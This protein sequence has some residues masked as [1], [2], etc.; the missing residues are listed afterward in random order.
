MRL[1]QALEWARTATFDIAVLDIN[2]DGCTSFPVADVL[3]ERGIPFTFITGY[4]AAGLEPPYDAWSVVKKPFDAAMLKS[5]IEG[6][7]A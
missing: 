5:A 2:L 1:P 3:R 6:L 7:A 4:G